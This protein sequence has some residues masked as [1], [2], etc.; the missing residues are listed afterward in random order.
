MEELEPTTLEPPEHPETI[1][2][3]T[4]DASLRTRKEMGDLKSMEVSIRDF[5]LIQP[6]VLTWD[7]NRWKLLAGERRLRAMKSLG[8]TELRYPRHFVLREDLVD[9]R[10]PNILMIRQAIELEENLRRKQMTWTEE[11]EG[12]RRLLA[13]MQERYGVKEA[14]GLTRAEKAGTATFEQTGFS[15]RKLAEQLGETAA[16]TSNDI[17]L[18]KIMEKAPFLANMENKTTALNAMKDLLRK[19][20]ARME[21]KPDPKVT[22]PD[23]S[24]RVLV[25]VP[26]EAAQ[27]ALIKEMEARGYKADP[28]IV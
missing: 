19:L 12:K 24:Y 25:Y 10:D 11:V 9:S 5:G 27:V 17:T 1:H 16:Q 4:I 26:D 21:G 22:M 8:W 7:N 3:D 13:L 18:A 14:G 6:I 23:T 20:E 2:I 28:V 15:L